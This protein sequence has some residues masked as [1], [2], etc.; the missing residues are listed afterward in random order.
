M[1]KIYF[2]LILFAGFTFKHANAQIDTPALINAYYT[3]DFIFEG[4]VQEICYFED[5]S[6]GNIYTNNQILITKIFKGDITC[7]TINIITPGGE[8]NGYELHV[9][10]QTEFTAGVAGVFLCKNNTYPEPTCG[11]SPT[12]TQNVELTQAFQG[13]IEYLFDYV[14]AEVEGFNSQFPSIQAFYDF[15]TLNGINITYCDGAPIQV[16]KQKAYAKRISKAPLEAIRERIPTPYSIDRMYPKNRQDQI[17]NMIQNTGNSGLKKTSY[18]I[19]YSMSQ[20]TLSG[21]G[22]NKEYVIEISIKSNTNLTY[23]EG[24]IFQLQYNTA[25][26]GT[27]IY[28]GIT[29][30]RTSAFP[31][32]NYDFVGGFDENSNTVQFSIQHTSLTPNRIQVTTTPKPLIVIHIPVV[33]CKVL[34][35]FIMPTLT[36][37]GHASYAL[38]ATSTA[39]TPGYDPEIYGAS[40]V[41]ALGD[42][43]VTGLSTT[44]LN[45]GRNE[46]LTIDGCDFGSVKGSISMNNADGS[47][48]SIALDKYDITLWSNSQI[49]INMP[50]QVDSGHAISSTA[51]KKHPVGTGP[52]LISTDFG[53]TT[54]SDPVTIKSAVYNKR[55]ITGGTAKMN[56]FLFSANSDGKFHFKLHP[57]ITNPKMIW[58]IKAAFRRWTCTTGVPFILDEGTYTANADDDGINIVKLSFTSNNAQTWTRAVYSCSNGTTTPYATKEIDIEINDN[59]P[60]FKFDTLGIVNVETD[61]IDFFRTILHE[62][63]HGLCLDHTLNIG[64]IMFYTSRYGTYIPASSRT[65]IIKDND[66]NAGNYVVSN[67]TTTPTGMTC[68]YNI[69]IQLQ[70]AHCNFNNGIGDIKHD[71]EIKVYPN[72]FKN[73]LTVSFNTKIPE[74]LK[75]RIFNILGEEIY[76]SSSGN[77]GGDNNIELN[78]FSFNDGVYFLIINDGDKFSFTKKIVCSK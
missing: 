51:Y 1:K 74:N 60:A 10:H 7:G 11:N 22:C 63:G 8:M 32:S 47:P 31:S 62:I 46:I 39:A 44:S 52:L 75:I 18:S 55:D 69:P 58:C 29:F 41:G 21:L 70:T 61:S 14:N 40:N 42:P 27:N 4:V 3:S 15:L 35:N 34:A 59:Q 78:N 9:S 43:T 72:P 2:I 36:G 6:T 33:N 17:V 13:T 30:G 53:T 12:N 56:E 64:D 45:A 16:L 20:V 65:I 71:N 48:T 76:S 54:T 77:I 68:A 38:S 23:L 73:G 19:E 28:S 67:S 49:K 24:A 37:F 5:A 57:N 66:L 26:F 50:S 25:C